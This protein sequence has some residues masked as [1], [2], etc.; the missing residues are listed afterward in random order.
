MTG[1]IAAQ[2]LYEAGAKVI[3]VSDSTDLLGIRRVAN[4]VQIR[5]IYP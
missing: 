2:L 3:A 5:G 1:S 4:A